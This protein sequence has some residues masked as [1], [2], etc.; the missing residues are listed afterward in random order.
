MIQYTTINKSDISTQVKFNNKI[1]ASPLV[2]RKNLNTT[3]D[4]I[5]LGTEQ[6]DFD[7]VAELFYNPPS[8][9]LIETDH[10]FHLRVKLLSIYIKVKMP[11]VKIIVST[12]PSDA[13]AI[14]LRDDCEVDYI[15]ATDNVNYDILPTIGICD[16][17]EDYVK[18][19]GM[20]ADLMLV[21]DDEGYNDALIQ[22]MYLTNSDTIE[23]FQVKG[24]YSKFN[25]AD[26]NINNSLSAT[27]TTH[28]H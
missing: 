15:I 14:Y 25:Y 4:C 19:V 17:V 10:P 7:K 5:V 12:V 26:Y 21:E 24:L 13:C 28:A 16:N 1:F 20:G 27:V 18:G 23:S 11:T 9:I 2:K 22:E 3:L 8:T 6:E